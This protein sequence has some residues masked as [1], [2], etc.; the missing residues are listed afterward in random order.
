[1]EQDK[2]RQKSR[3]RLFILVG[4]MVAMMIAANVIMYV[5]YKVLC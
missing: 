4:G 2:T 1:M 5:V 3:R